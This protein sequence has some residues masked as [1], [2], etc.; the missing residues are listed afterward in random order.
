MATFHGERNKRPRRRWRTAG[1]LDRWRCRAQPGLLDG[2]ASNATPWA[3]A[4]GASTATRSSSAAAP[5]HACAGCDRGPHPSSSA[6]GTRHPLPLTRPRPDCCATHP[7]RD[8]IRRRGCNRASAP[9]ASQRRHRCATPTI[10]RRHPHRQ[11]ANRPGSL[12]AVAGSAD[13]RLS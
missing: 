6:A 12:M 9:N 11:A 7:V 13:A 3:L 2:P 1:G 5:A 10:V 4:V 8:A